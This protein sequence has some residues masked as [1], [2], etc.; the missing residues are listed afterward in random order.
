MNV[1][2]VQSTITNKEININFQENLERS[3]LS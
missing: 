3:I 1:E 2:V